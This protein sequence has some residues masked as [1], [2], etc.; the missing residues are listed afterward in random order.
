MGLGGNVQARCLVTD[1]NKTCLHK[2][3]KR[4]ETV[5]GGLSMQE[6]R[7]CAVNVAEVLSSAWHQQCYAKACP[8]C[9]KTLHVA[10]AF[11]KS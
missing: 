8:Q 1:W 2:R 10:K 9:Y 11:I 4:C 7:L 5:A 6:P 3:S